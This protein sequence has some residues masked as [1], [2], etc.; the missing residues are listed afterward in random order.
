ML[1]KSGKLASLRG[2]E[3][4]GKLAGSVG[5]LKFERCVDTYSLGLPAALLARGNRR[6]SN[7]LG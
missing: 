5:R 6:F 7:G 4:V 3:Q 2:D 1:D